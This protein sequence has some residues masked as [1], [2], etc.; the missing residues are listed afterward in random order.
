MKPPRAKPGKW[1]VGLAL[2]AAVLAGLFAEPK[3][4]TSASGELVTFF[5]I[6]AAALLPAM[7]L[8]AT[9]L[10]PEGLSPNEVRRYRHALHGQMVFWSTLL[11]L[12]FVAA[13]LIIA[14]KAAD[15]TFPNFD[16]PFLA[17]MDVDKPIIGSVAFVGSLAIIRMFHAVVGIFSLMKVNLDL[18]DKAVVDR[19]TREV[20]DRRKVATPFKAPEGYG[21]V[22]KPPRMRSPS[23]QSRTPPKLP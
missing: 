13:A 10:R 12:D 7:L 23:H 5:G 8:T 9:I 17:P 11:A 21:K 14:G 4:L 15:W 22:V 2:A 1:D 16:L 20:E 3:A 18:V 19:V 6:Q